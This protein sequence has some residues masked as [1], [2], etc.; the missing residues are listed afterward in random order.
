MSEKWKSEINEVLR[1]SGVPSTQEITIVVLSHRSETTIWHRLEL[2]CQVF[3]RQF[4]RAYPS[5]CINWQMACLPL[6]GEDDVVPDIASAHILL[7]IVSVECLL[8]LHQLPPLY[9]VLAFSPHMP[10]RAAIV[11]RSAPLGNEQFRFAAQFPTDAPSLALCQEDDEV[12]T[13]V[14]KKIWDWARS[15]SKCL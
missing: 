2:F 8:E 3:T 1:D 4:T 9:A 5:V 10:H 14:T 15:I 7:M 12:Y 6:V 11:A 13:E